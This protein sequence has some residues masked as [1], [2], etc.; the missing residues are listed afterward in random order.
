[1]L[2]SL[3][4]FMGYNIKAPVNIS[5]VASIWILN[6]IM[7]LMGFL[8][9][10]GKLSRMVACISGFI[11]FILM[12]FIIYVNFIKPKYNTANTILF[13]LYACIWSL[14]GIVYLLSEEYKNISMNVLDLCAKC[15][16]G[17]GM[18]MYFINVIRWN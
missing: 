4:L 14:Y 16:V 6:Y 13:S 8:G 18:W 9:E 5:T 7:L 11:P 17:I 2:L 3:S 10:I 1:M 12:I 15:L